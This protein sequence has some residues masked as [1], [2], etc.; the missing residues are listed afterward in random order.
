M[1]VK[2]AYRIFLRGLGPGSFADPPHRGMLIEMARNQLA[3]GSLKRLQ[4]RIA[5]R[6]E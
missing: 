2:H 4:R 5:G 6:F 1:R 3:R